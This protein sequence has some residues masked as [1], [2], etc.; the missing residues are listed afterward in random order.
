[1]RLEGEIEP[2]DY[3]RMVVVRRI[4]EGNKSQ[5]RRN[6]E[7]EC[8]SDETNESLGATEMPNYS[9][10]SLETVRGKLTDGGVEI[11]EGGLS[12]RKILDGKPVIELA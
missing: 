9:K 1:M 6:L 4:E 8:P 11:G 10:T 12:G 2:G 5:K 3:A 7:R